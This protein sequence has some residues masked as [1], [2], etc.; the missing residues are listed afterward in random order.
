MTKDKKKGKRV[1]I[2]APS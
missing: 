1:F 2:Q